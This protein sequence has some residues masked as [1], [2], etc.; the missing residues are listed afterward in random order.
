MHRIFDLVINGLPLP[1]LPSSDGPANITANLVSHPWRSETPDWFHHW[2]N[3]RGAT[4][5]SCA[6]L[7]TGYLVAVP[8]IGY[9]HIDMAYRRIEI[10]PE[11]RIPIE[12]IRHCLLDQI[13]P[14]YVGQLGSLVLHASAVELSKNHMVAFAGETG[15]GKSTLASAFSRRG[16]LLCTDDC[17]LLEKEDDEFYGKANY[18]GVRLYDDSAQEIFGQIGKPG[19][20]S[21]STEKKRL[22]LNSEVYVSSARMRLQ[23]LF[24]IGEPSDSQTIEIEQADHSK[25]AMALVRQLFYLDPKDKNLITRQFRNLQDLTDSNVAIYTLKIP[26]NYDRIEDVCQAVEDTIGL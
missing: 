21:H 16:S 10:Y 25:G 13:I 26:Q 7:G 23:G 3:S 24:L 1:E 5:A 4:T 18:P 19:S 8:D 14:M 22:L 17:L 15:S 12:S 9:F 11:K 6:N 20:V 2:K